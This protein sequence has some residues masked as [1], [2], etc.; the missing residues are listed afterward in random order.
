MKVP[1]NLTQ[2]ADAVKKGKQTQRTTVRGLLKSFGTTRRGTQVTKEIKQQLH[3]FGLDT[4]PSFEDVD[5]DSPVSYVVFTGKPVTNDSAHNDRKQVTP[6]MDRHAEIRDLI[7]DVLKAEFA[8]A[9]HAEPQPEALQTLSIDVSE[10]AMIR[11]KALQEEMAPKADN[12]IFT[13]M[14]DLFTVRGSL[15]T[16][17][18]TQ[19]NVRRMA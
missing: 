10:G 6:S 1:A 14:L 4:S 5:M 13:S 3:A 15:T 8:K 11:W 18:P 2:I 16:K 12:E 9:A 17:T 7:R 19:V